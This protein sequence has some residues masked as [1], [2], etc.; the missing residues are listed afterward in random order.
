MFVQADLIDFL[1]S[2]VSVPG[3]ERPSSMLELSG[4]PHDAPLTVLHFCSSA[5]HAVQLT[6]LY[7]GHP[8]AWFEL[9]P[10]CLH[11]TNGQPE[12]AATSVL[13]TLTEQYSEQ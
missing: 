5:V 7:S 11:I 13:E 12:G 4:C 2:A 3:P 8:G 6:S 9:D 1:R 10:S